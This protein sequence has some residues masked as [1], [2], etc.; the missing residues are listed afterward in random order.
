MNQAQIAELFGRDVSVVS[1]H[2]SDVLEDGELD[3]ESNL[4]KCKLLEPRARHDL[5][6]GHGDIS[7]VSPLLGAGHSVQALATEKL[8]QFATKGFVVDTTRLKAP[9]NSDRIAELL[10]DRPPK[11]HTRP[12]SGAAP[13]ALM[14]PS[15][16][17]ASSGSGLRPWT[18]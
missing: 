9:A 17:L 11:S 10:E 5:Q 8:L 7:R 15:S 13:S 2:I 4:Q 6:L 14:L 18:M 1:R 16:S 3:E 12:A